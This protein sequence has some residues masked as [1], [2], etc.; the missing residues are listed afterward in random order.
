LEHSTFDKT[1]L[2]KEAKQKVDRILFDGLREGA[3]YGRVVS[4]GWWE[5]VNHI[6]DPSSEKKDQIAAQIKV[7]RPRK[8]ECTHSR[9]GIM[10]HTDGRDLL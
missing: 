1:S 9:G 7:N 4:V 3:G 2:G 6:T 8:Q 5:A 10:K